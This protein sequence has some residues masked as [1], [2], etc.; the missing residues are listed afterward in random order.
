MFNHFDNT[1]QSVWLFGLLILCAILL[2]GSFIF[3]KP[4]EKNT[5]RMA[6]LPRLLTS[7]LLVIAGWS[8]YLFSRDMRNNTFSLLIAVGMSLCFIGDLFM[9][10]ASIPGGIGAF[11]LGHVVYIAALIAFGDQHGLNAAGP[12]L[13]AWFAWLLIGLGGWYLTVYRGQTKRTAL[14]Y[15]AVLYA[16]LVAS[17]AGLAT[18]LALQQPLFIPLAVGAALFLSSDLI[19]AGQ[20]FSGLYFP[21]IGDIVWLT[22]GP[23]QMLIVFSIDSA[24]I[25]LAR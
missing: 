12:R 4:D 16:L 6:P 13:I 11:G 17:T 24:L 21:L 14:H 25:V 23:A 20:L 3:G 8:W 18:G 2:L 15:I 7:V 22:Y 5:R 9:A 1:L 19:L 10:R